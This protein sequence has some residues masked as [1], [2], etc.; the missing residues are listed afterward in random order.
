MMTAADRR[1]G[2]SADGDADPGTTA[3]PPNRPPTLPPTG[4][5]LAV[6]W[7]EK[8]IGLAVTDPTRTIAQPLATLRRRAGRRFPLQQLRHHLDALQPVGIVVG[9]PLDE[10]GAEGP[11]ARAARAVAELLAEKTG[12]PVVLM[13][14]RMTT[15]RARE[16]EP[17]G[18]ARGATG[19]V[20]LDQR[21][22]TVLLQL[23]LERQRA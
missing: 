4:R 12:L 22:A 2:G 6:D 18:A 8:R 10:D 16:A 20:D 19:G 1:I 11:S 17:R 3:Q 5:L 9:L 21:A 13:D 15:A 7:G 14:E 23:Y